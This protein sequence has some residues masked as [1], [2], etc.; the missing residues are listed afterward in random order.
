MKNYWRQLKNFKKRDLRKNIKVIVMDV[1]GTLTDGVIN[2]ARDGEL[3][4]SFYC[5]DGLAII[6]AEKEGLIPIILTSRVS[7]IVKRRSE[8]LKIKHVY[9]GFIDD[10]R[11]QLKKILDEL[12]L[13]WQNIAYI[14]DDRNDLECMKE[15]GIVGCP[16]DAVR[17]VK[18]KADYV[19][20]HQGGR[21]AVREFIDW[22]IEGKKGS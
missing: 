3:F 4:K 7:E 22:I 14:G 15:C 17:D 10:K 21:G 1:D 2:I 12:H 6:S 5:R 18:K 9:Q 19:C 13:N 11:M 8:E 20:M 16:S